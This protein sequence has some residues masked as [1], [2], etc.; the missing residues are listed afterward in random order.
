MNVRFIPTF[1]KDG[2]NWLI[3]VVDSAAENTGTITEFSDI[4]G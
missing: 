3:R 4:I 1:K 2:Y